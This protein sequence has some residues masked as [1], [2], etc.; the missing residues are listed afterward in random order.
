MH[1][2]FL[3]ESITWGGQQTQIY[4]LI[5]KLKPKTD[6]ITWLYI[7]GE[8][9]KNSFSKTI[10][11]SKVGDGYKNKDYIYR[12]WKVIAAIFDT[13]VFLKRYPA[14]VII[15]AHGLGSLI[16]GLVGKITN[17]PHFRILGNDMATSE[18]VIYKLYRLICFDILIDR[19]FGFE[20]Q[21]NQLLIKGVKPYKFVNINHAVDANYYYP[22]DRNQKLK[23]KKELGYNEE[24]II[25]GWVGRIAINMQLKNT[26]ILFE[27]LYCKYPKKF[28][29]LIVGG[30]PWL[31]DLKLLI[32]K[33]E[34]ANSVQFLGW[35]PLD[36]INFFY[37]VMDFVP[38]LENDPWGGSI[39]REALAAGSIT[40][41]VDGNSKVQKDFML[42]NHAF[43]VSPNN[44]IKDSVK[45]IIKLSKNKS[46]R[47][48]I[49]I[50]A[51]NF[52]I[53]NL[54]FDRQAE[55]IYQTIINFRSQK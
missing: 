37:N 13:L 19:Y 9:F 16:L 5:K 53:A 41:S 34:F 8:D 11:F 20:A 54:T 17:T 50:K 47:R 31:K 38:L 45:I 43:L 7:F 46:K 36:R 52:A 10:D 40:I 14:D 39:L 24:D 23:I 32:S 1:I 18:R 44:F 51:R 35:Q 28:K 15:S 4:N 12:P 26:V 42:G 29:L 3:Y 48:D 55:I 30:G 49:S 2:V 25:V 27:K 33:K 6:K 22:I 21:L